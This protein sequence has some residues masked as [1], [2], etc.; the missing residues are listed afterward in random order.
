MPPVVQSMGFTPYPGHFS[1]EINSP[2][3]TPVKSMA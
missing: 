2:D 1:V 3:H